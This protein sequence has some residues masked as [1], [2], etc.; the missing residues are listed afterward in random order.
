MTTNTAEPQPEMTADDRRELFEI[1]D[2]VTYLNC[3]NMS[4]QLRSVTQVGVAAVS[5]KASPWTVRPE[6]W[7]APTER[8]RTLFARIINGDPDGVAIVPSVSYGIAVAAANLPVAS[9]QSIVLLDGEFP[10]NVYAWHDLARRRAAVVRTVARPSTSAWTDAL[11]D[12]IDSTT[13]VVSV[14]NCH[15]T[16]GRLVDLPRVAAA[17][18]RAGAALVIDGSQ[19]VGAY[20]L[21]VATIEP[22]FLVTVGYKWLLGPYGL[23]YLY[24]APRWRRSGVPLEHSWLTRAGA[25]DFTCLTDYSD[26]FRQGA[27]RFDMGEFPQFVLTAMAI[28]ALE[29]VLEW[30][31]DRVQKVIS[32]LTSRAEEGVRNAEGDAVRGTD[33]VGHLIGIRPRA[34]V[35]RDLISALTGA[36]VYVSVRGDAIRVAPHLYN[37]GAD[38]ERLLDVLRAHS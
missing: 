28:A 15:W 11:I 19:S 34:G 6:D 7:F 36:K 12:A 24:I 35:R 25:E 4:P 29:Q 23:A 26:N 31:V 37:T 5:G 1:P 30:S 32:A 2:D 3:A 9:G 13:A 8:L 38:I 20:S 10:S 21:D 27:R 33:R 22:D 17:A 16:D 14:P 18:R